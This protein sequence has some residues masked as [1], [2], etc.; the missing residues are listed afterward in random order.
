MNARPPLNVAVIGA[1]YFA[2][3]HLAAWRRLQN[4]GLVHCLLV[5]DQD[6]RRASAA[7]VQHGFDIVASDVDVLFARD[8]VDVVD[9]VTPPSTHESLVT[10]CASKRIPAICQ[11]PLTDTWDTS[12]RL[13]NDVEAETATLLVH[14]NFRFMP[15]YQELKR[16]VDSGR[17]GTLHQVWFRLR[18]GDGRGA[19]AYLNR[20]PYFQKMPRFLVHET[21]IHWID[22][23]RFLMGEM[24][25][26]TARLMQRNPAIAGEDCGY[27]LFDFANG[28]TGAIDANRHLDHATDKPFRT[29]GELWLEGERATA[30]VDGYGRI[31]MRDFGAV[32][33]YLHDYTWQDT[34]FGGDCVYATQRAAIQH[35]AGQATYANTARAYL[36]NIEIE[37]AIYAS[38]EKRMTIA[39]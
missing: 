24:S 23:F 2:Q 37:E 6:A 9:I 5:C 26:V 21:L 34:G 25:A 13:V 22:T 35:L 30:Q 20:Q 4:E 16:L 7:G 19:Q 12:Q 18:T 39:V 36:R 17:L 31:W 15:W 14:E 1:G 32:Q 11:K 10:Q 3:Q 27:V 8:D 33:E 29:L 38:H 28:A